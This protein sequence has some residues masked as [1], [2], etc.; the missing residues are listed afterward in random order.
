MHAPEQFSGLGYMENLI[1]NNI[2]PLSSY[3]V[4]FY[5]L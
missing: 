5:Q 2:L 4:G 3:F 1:D